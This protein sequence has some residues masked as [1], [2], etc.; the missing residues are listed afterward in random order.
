ML[1]MILSKNLGFQELRKALRDAAGSYMQRSLKLPTKDLI[2]FP[3]RSGGSFPLS[4][5]EVGSGFKCY[6]E[7][8]F[9][10]LFLFYFNISAFHRLQE[11]YVR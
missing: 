10:G 3:L 6:C 1:F 4:C 9:R 11:D 7:K 2:L 5:I 8:K